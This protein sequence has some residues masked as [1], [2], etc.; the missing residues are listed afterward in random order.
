MHCLLFCLSGCVFLVFVCLFVWLV[1]FFLSKFVYY[2]YDYCLLSPYRNSS[3]CVCGH[4]DLS[5]LKLPIDSL[6]ECAASCE[7]RQCHSCSSWVCCGLIWLQLLDSHV[8]SPSHMRALCA[9]IWQNTTPIL[10]HERTLRQQ[11]K[12][13]HTP[14][15][16][17]FTL[18]IRPSQWD[19]LD[20]Y[21]RQNSISYLGV[22]GYWLKG[23][24]LAN[25]KKKGL[26][27]YR[28]RKNIWKE[29]GW[30]LKCN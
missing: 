5:F 11:R 16:S 23:K 22:Y 7:W 10:L 29:G 26:K 28:W 2:V 13:Y 25:W 1:G 27:T 3:Q 21:L 30:V 14:T 17:F 19:F 4:L 20:S 15:Q 6:Q 24:N 9:L 18:S 8:S 12:N